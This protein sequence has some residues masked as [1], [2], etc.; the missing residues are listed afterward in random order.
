M[1]TSGLQPAQAAGIIGLVFTILLITFAVLL[2]PFI[3]YLLTLQKALKRCSPEVRA[4][5]PAMVWLMFIPL[6]NIVWHFIVV[7]NLA[8]SLA[9]EFRRRGI[10]EEPAPGKTIGLT[11]CILHCCGIIPFLGVLC[12]L[13]GLICWIIYWVKIAG[14]SG[15]LALPLYQP[16]PMPPHAV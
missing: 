11:M 14:F 2:V 1:E 8:K 3:F 4:M 15:K 13:G 10:A 16:P 9:G 5:E 12:S 6:F 7:G